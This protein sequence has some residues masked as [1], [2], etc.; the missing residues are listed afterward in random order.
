MAEKK[1]RKTFLFFGRNIHFYIGTRAF[2][3]ANV[4]IPSRNVNRRRQKVA[5]IT[6]N[7]G[8]TRG[9]YSGWG[10]RSRARIICI[11]PV[12][13]V[14][15]L[16]LFRV[17]YKSLSL[18][19]CPP[20]L[21]HQFRSFVLLEFLSNRERKGWKKRNTNLK[22][23]ANLSKVDGLVFRRL[24]FGEI[25]FSL[26]RII[27]MAWLIHF[28]LVR[29]KN[30]LA[31]IA[32]KR[33]EKRN[34]QIYFPLFLFF[35]PFQFRFSLGLIARPKNNKFTLTR[36]EVSPPRI[37]GFCRAAARLCFKVKFRRGKRRIGWNSTSRTVL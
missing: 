30:S 20:T 31:L 21:A 7:G 2:R 9:A 24:E 27:F 18:S 10:G 32:P 33:F 26:R 29:F 4:R 25:L 35:W 34:F 13:F 19:L 5:R 8:G 36:N 6:E 11:F 12:V 1:F 3:R 22:G 28:F 37:D 14:A 23:L 15:R 17:N 16:N